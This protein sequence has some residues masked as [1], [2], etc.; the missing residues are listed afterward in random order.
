MKTLAIA[1]A[2]FAASVLALPTA[3]HAADCDGLDRPV[4]F[5]GLDWDSVTFHNAVAGFMLEHGY[6][7][8]V[9]SIPGSTIPLFNGMIRGDI[10]VTMEVWIPNIKDAWDK[11]T[12]DGDVASVGVSFPDASQAWYV[13]RYLVEGEDAPAPDLKSVADLPKYASLF[14][15]PEDPDKGRFYNCILGWGCEV[16]NTKK[17]IAYGLDESFNNFRPG[18]GGAL[19]SAIESALLR[20]RPIVFYYWGP[21]WVLGKVGPDLIRLEEPAYDEASWQ[22]LADADVDEVTT[23]TPAMAW[24]DTPADIGVNTEFQE[25]TPTLMEFFGNY[26]F[27]AAIVSESLNFM[28]ENSASAEE[29]AVEWLKSNED[30]WTT[31]VPADAADRIKAALASA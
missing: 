9:D 14:Q 20:E 1:A 3:A 10:D 27:T 29:A 4:V 24:P 18:T 28:R 11:A 15:D 17:L 19:S 22:V 26:G 6:G 31:W 5:A 16:M 12:A 2:G 25:Q 21:T 13:P 7:C 8:E 23:D 30:T